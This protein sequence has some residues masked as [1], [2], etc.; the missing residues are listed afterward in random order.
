M[1]G[2]AWGGPVHT[3]RVELSPHRGQQLA[4]PGEPPAR[5]LGCSQPCNIPRPATRHSGLFCALLCFSVTFL[6]NSLLVLPLGIRSLRT[7]NT[8]CRT[9]EHGAHWEGLRCVGCARLACSLLI[10][11][12]R[13]PNGS[14]RPACQQCKRSE[15]SVAYAFEQM[16]VHVC[17]WLACSPTPLQAQ[18]QDFSLQFCYSRNPHFILSLSPALPAELPHCARPG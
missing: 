8:S 12:A 9:L 18:A 1:T 11:A 14:C 17:A 15:Q 13:C 2:G 16:R 10:W 4:G 6:S 7:Q 5:A 3:Q